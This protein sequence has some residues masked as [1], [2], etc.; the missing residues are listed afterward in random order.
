M[1]ISTRYQAFFMELRRKMK[2]VRYFEMIFCLIIFLLIAGV[3][4][5]D[6]KMPSPHLFN[7][8]IVYIEKSLWPLYLAFGFFIFIITLY[9][10]NFLLIF[11]I[12]T[13]PGIAVALLLSAFLKNTNFGM[14]LGGVF[15]ASIPLFLFAVLYKSLTDEECIGGGV[16]KLAAMIGAFLGSTK[17]LIAL[18]LSALIAVPCLYFQFRNNE[19]IIIEVGPLLSIFSLSTVLIPYEEYIKLIFSLFIKI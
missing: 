17:V 12:F 9:E 6:L 10:I 1:E 19:K 2:A 4:F 11:D 15:S 16:I 3:G 14:H 13:I 8:P 7:L 5:A 18:L